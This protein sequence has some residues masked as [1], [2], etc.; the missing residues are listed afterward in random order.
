M[1]VLAKTEAIIL[2]YV[3]IRLG[4]FLPEGNNFNKDN[5][6]GFLYPAP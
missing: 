1:V 5:F 6:S 3:N 4:V 2:F